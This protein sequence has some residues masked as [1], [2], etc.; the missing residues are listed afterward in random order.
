[1]IK[2]GLLSSY[3]WVVLSICLALSPALPGAAGAQSAPGTTSKTA[4]SYADEPVVIVASD[5]AYTYA[6]DGTGSRV[7]TIVE[8]LQSDA[9][10]KQFGLVAIPYASNSEQVEILY[11]RVRHPD[12]SVDPTPVTDAIEMPA[13]VTREAPLYSDLKEMQ[14]PIRSLRVGDTLEWRARI[15]CTKAEVPGNFWNDESTSDDSVVLAESI[16]LRVPVTVKL[17]VWSPQLNPV[18][19]TADGMHIYRW[20]SAQLKPTAGKEADS[21]AEL[22]KKTQWTADH[23]LDEDQGKL[24]TVAWTTFPSW[25]AVG[26]WYH[27]LEADRIAPDA[28]I[29]AKVAEL[30]AGKSTDEAKARALYNYV[31][32]NIRYIGVDFG[33]GRY[34]PHTA[35]E[36]LSNQYGDCKDKH[37]LLAAMLQAAGI[38]SDAVL[39]GVNIRFNQAVPSPAAFNHL[40]TRTTIAGQPVWLDTTTEVAPWRLLSYP[41]RDRQALVVPATGVAHIEHSPVDPPTPNLQTMHSVGKLNESGES[42]SH[43]EFSF[44]GDSELLMRTIFRPIAPAQYNSTVQQFS[45]NIGYGGTTSNAELSRAADTAKPFTMAYDYKREKAGDWSNLKTIPQL[46]PITLPAAGDEAAVRSILLGPLH[47]EI[48]TS[49]MKLPE[50]WRA[51]LPEAKHLHSV[52][53]NYDVTY[54]LTDGTLYAER[55]L[56]TLK[57][58]VPVSDWK[59]YKSWL[60]KVEPGSEPY[61][62]L[63][64]AQTGAQTAAKTDAKAGTNP[65]QPVHTDLTPSNQDA[66]K[67]IQTAVTLIEAKDLDGAQKTLDQ[68]AQ[69]HPNQEMYWNT[70]AQ[71]HI[72]R[73]N[74]AEALADYAKELDYHPNE[75]SIIYPRI[76]SLDNS[77]GQRKESLAVTRHW[78]EV[79]PDNPKPISQII[80]ALIRAGDAAAAVKEFAAAHLSDEARKDL[81]L[82]VNLGRAMLLSGDKTR[83]AAVLVAVLQRTDD[84][85]TANNVAYY[86]SEAGVELPLAEKIARQAVEQISQETRGWTLDEDPKLLR[87]RS[88]NLFSDWDTLGWIL[89]RE[90]KLD[91]A[92]GYINA[93]WNNDPSSTLGEHLGEILAAKGD[94]VAALGAYMLALA[95]NP[96]VAGQPASAERLNIESRI[97][98]LKQAGVV[99]GITDPARQLASMRTIAI[100]AHDGRNQSVNYRILLKN[101]T[102][103]KV[104]PVNQRKMVDGAQEM[105]ARAKFAAYFPAKEDAQIVRNGTINCQAGSCELTLGQ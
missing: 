48:S 64:R 16:E 3:P 17:N 81:S 82:Q 69:L 50:G 29:K 6:A 40:I 52:Y 85:F 33:I 67:L 65:A 36:I 92:R 105:I 89:F 43:I 63:V 91:E 90:G 19:T 31:A 61:V 71:I 41:I 49:E 99:S 2:P 87:E 13:E 78:A 55:R 93:A 97:E 32:T 21:A 34:Q 62:Q 103:A 35:A 98:A 8:R 24:P 45:T 47:Q 54:R 42:N 11:A 53:A 46:A 75:S 102:V 79:E 10:V 39:I 70:C 56:E 66:A 1:M 25:E 44:S 101:G 60:D 96:V 23:E 59:S 5:T 68:A 73:G 80:D 94:K 15:T 12:G 104:A 9:A 7:L 95:T 57:D 28:T 58:R 27:A 37:T 76:I 51:V 86:L 30:T 84:P 18:E 26:A 20:S 74:Q 14:L 77:M 38:D 83:G 72:Q 4:P 100:G 22:K 88:H